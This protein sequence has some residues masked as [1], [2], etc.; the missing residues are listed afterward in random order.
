MIIPIV[1]FIASAAFGA[2]TALSNSAEVEIVKSHET[3]RAY[4]EQYYADEPV[5]AKIA[6]CESRLRHIDA[7]GEILRGKVDSDDI[8]VMQINTRYHEE[9]AHELGLDLYSL[10]G[11]LSYARYLY[12]KE[13]TKPWNSSR[14][15]WDKLAQK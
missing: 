10:N 7:D 5:L 8:G 15:C 12:E 14:P 4:V 13:G 3:L 9:K 11:N 6:W 1:F 2:P